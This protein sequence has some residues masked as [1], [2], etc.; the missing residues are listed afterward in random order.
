MDQ[1]SF[2][3][4]GASRR[5]AV[6]EEA[7]AAVRAEAEPTVPKLRAIRRMVTAKLKTASGEDVRMIGGTLVRVGQRWMGYE[8]IAAHPEALSGITLK[9]I[10]ALGEGMSTW[11]QVD[12]FGVLLAGEAWRA[13]AIADRDIKRWAASRDLWWRRAA[14]V[15]TTVL[16]G[17]TRGGK[18]DAKRT[19]M[20][21]GMLVADQED[22]VVKA[23]SWALRS[24]IPWD[25]SAVERF[26]VKHDADLAARVKR[27][28]RNKLKTGLKTP[29]KAKG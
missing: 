18:G 17:K 2:E 7:V 6:V 10:E 5:M 3:S 23:M 26:L 24:L 22:M 19:L 16:N 20:I 12:T 4:M 28:V 27:E 9:E 21:A 15:A 13:G 14:L 25:A 1:T 11:D 29:K 8:V